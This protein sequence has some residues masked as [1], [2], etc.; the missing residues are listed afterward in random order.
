MLFRSISFWV[1]IWSEYRSSPSLG[2]PKS[3][4]SLLPPK[5]PVEKAPLSKS[6]ETRLSVLR[7]VST[8]YRFYEH[9]I[10]Y[11][12]SKVI[13]SCQYL[14]CQFHCSMSLYTDVFIFHLLLLKIYRDPLLTNLNKIKFKSNLL[15]ISPALFTLIV[16]VV[17]VWVVVVDSNIMGFFPVG[18]NFYFALQL[19]P[20]CE[21]FICKK[22][23]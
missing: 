6:L 21:L 1:G 4:S 20:T 3:S 5:P 10:S 19:S 23:L 17:V 14:L 15:S 16:L 8:I 7:S 9:M 22:L 11:R 18:S 13:R 2:S 12:V